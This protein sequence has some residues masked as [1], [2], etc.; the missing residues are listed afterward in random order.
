MTYLILTTDDTDCLILLDLAVDT[1]GDDTMIPSL[2]QILGMVG[3][4]IGGI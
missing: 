1:M 3:T 2:Y 4:R